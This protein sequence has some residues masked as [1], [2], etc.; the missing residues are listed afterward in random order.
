M[1]E[2]LT[3]YEPETDQ[4]FRVGI[5]AQLYLVSAWVAFSLPWMASL[6][7]YFS[8]NETL[9]HES[10]LAEYSMPNL[11]NSVDIARQSAV[12]VNGAF[13]LV[14]ASSRQEHEAVVI[15]VDQERAALGNIIRDLES[16]SAFGEYTRLIKEH[17]LDLG[18]HLEVIQ[19]SSA[20]RLTINQS[21]TFARRGTGCNQST[22]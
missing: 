10:R 11:I 3:P 19:E 1:M 5:G 20:R 16:R 7:A 17:L 6:V 4:K 9:R 14:A 13:L 18:K 21:L 15:T 12:V 22:H 2:P 8:F